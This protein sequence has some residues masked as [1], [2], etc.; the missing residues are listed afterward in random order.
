MPRTVLRQFTG[1]LSN[2]IDPQNLRE[3]QGEEAFDINLKGHA[4]EPGESTVPINAAGHYYYRGEWIE[5]SK[6][7]SFEESGIGVVKTFDSKRPVFEEI[8]KDDEN[9]SRNLGPPLPP[10]AVITGTIVSEGTRGERPGEGSHLLKLPETTLGGVDTTQSLE[11]HQADVTTAI[12][13]MHYYDGQPYWI[14][15][16]GSNNENWVIRT[17]KW[18]L[19][20][21]VVTWLT[22]YLD[23]TT[24]THNSGGS[25]FKDGYFVCWDD[26]YIDSVALSYTA[27]TADVQNTILDADGGDAGTAFSSSFLSGATGNSITGVDIDGNGII[28]FSQRMTTPNTTP[29][30][31]LYQNDRSDHERWLR[32]P[33]DS[34]NRGCF[35]VFLRDGMAHADSESTNVV[36]DYKTEA[37][38]PP[39]KVF[40]TEK[41]GD[42]NIFPGWETPTGK[43]K[44]IGREYD[45]HGVTPVSAKDRLQK[46]LDGRDD[47]DFGIKYAVIFAKNDTWVSVRYQDPTGKPPEMLV[48]PNALQRGGKTGEQAAKDVTCTRTLQS[49]K[50]KSTWSVTQ[51]RLPTVYF[52]GR[53]IGGGDHLF[54]MGYGQIWYKDT[55]NIELTFPTLSIHH[56]KVKWIYTAPKD[57]GFSSYA[58][59]NVFKSEDLGTDY[60]RR[61]GKSWRD[62]QFLW[63]FQSTQTGNNGTSPD[64]NT[65]SW[66]RLV[67]DGSGMGLRPGWQ[68][69]DRTGD[70]SYKNGTV[71][72]PTVAGKMH[73]LCSFSRP[74]GT[75]VQQEDFSV[76]ELWTYAK[77]SGED[78][79]ISFAEATNKNF[80]VGD[81]IKIGWNGTNKSMHL[82]LVGTVRKEIDDHW[83][84][85]KMEQTFITAKIIGI[86][87]GKLELSDPEYDHNKNKKYIDEECYPLIT[88]FIKYDSSRKVTVDEA[89]GGP[90]CS[91]IKS[92]FSSHVLVG[93]STGRLFLDTPQIGLTE[94][95]V[96]VRGAGAEGINAAGFNQLD[97][98]H[99]IDWTGNEVRAVEHVVDSYRPRIFYTKGGTLYS[100]NG[101]NNSDPRSVNLSINGKYYVDGK[102]LTHI[103][104]KDIT[105][106]SPNLQEEFVKARPKLPSGLG[107]KGEIQDARTF[108]NSSNAVFV[109][110]KIGG[111][112]KV[113]R[114]SNIPKVG[115]ETSLLNYD[116]N[117]PI[118]FD[119]TKIWGIGSSS[120]NGWDLQNATPFYESDVIGSYVYFASTYYDAALS[121]AATALNPTKSAWG[122]V[123]DT[124]LGDT[125]DTGTPRYLSVHWETDSGLLNSTGTPTIGLNHES[126][127]MV[128]EQTFK[129]YPIDYPSA[130]YSGTPN[131]TTPIVISDIPG[132]TYIPISS[133]EISF[134]S[135][136]KRDV[137]F[138]KK[139]ETLLPSAGDTGGEN[140]ITFLNYTD[141][142]QAFYVLSDS[143]F[144][145]TDQVGREPEVAFRLGQANV[146]NS[147][148][149][150]SKV[151]ISSFLLGAPNMFNAYGPNIDIYYRASF[152][153]KWG[154][155]G[156][157]SPLPSKGIAPLNS[158]DDCVQVNFAAPFFKLTD[159]DIEKIRLYRY[160]G[161]SSEFLYLRDID[162]PVL[163]VDSDGNSYFPTISGF[164]GNVA[165]KDSNS[166]FY[167]L[168]TN[169][170]ISILGGFVNSNFD[171]TTTVTTASAQ[172]MNGSW[173]INQLSE[174]ES[175]SVVYQNELDTELT[176]SATTIVTDS[177]NAIGGWPSSG[178]VKIDDEYISYTGITHPNI[179]GCTRG[180]YNSNAVIHKIKQLNA[181]P[182]Q[183]T[184]VEW[185]LEMEHRNQDTTELKIEIE[186]PLTGSVITVAD[187]SVFNNSGQILIG[188]DIYNYTAKTAAGTG[189]ATADTFTT[190]T[191][192]SGPNSDHKTN[193]LVR[194]YN[195]VYNTTDI[196]STT[197]VIDGFGYRDKAR[198]PVASLH[199]M[200]VDNWPPLGIEYN[201]GTKRFFETESEDDYFRYIKAVGSM[202]FGA[203]DASLRFSK[204]GT[205]EYWPLEAVVTLDSEIR[206]IEEH[207]GE[208]IVFTTN[209]VYR[210]RGTDPKAMIAFRVPDAKGLPAGYEHTV[211]D[212]NGGLIWLTASDGIAMYQSGRVTYLTRDKH[213]IGEL[214]K[215]YSCV[216]DGVY[217]L[218]QEPG[219]G[220]GFRLELV[221]G[222]MRLAQTSIEAYYAYFAKALGI[223]V[224]VTKDN[225][226]NPNVDTEFVVEEIGGIKA[227]NIS[228]KSKKIDAGEPAIPKALGS[229]AIVYQALGSE[230][231]ETIVD[232]IRGQALAAQ[233]LGLDPADL[234]AGD[235]A[236]V[237]SETSSDLYSIFTKYNEPHQEFTVDIGGG[238]LTSLERRTIIMP[239][240][241]DATTVIAGDRIWN[242]LLADNT[243]VESSS[244]P[245]ELIDENFV[246]TAAGTG[247]G[248]HNDASFVSGDIV[249]ESFGVNGFALSVMCESRS[250]SLGWGGGSY[251][252]EGGLKIGTEVVFLEP[253]SGSR[254]PASIIAGT[255]YYIQGVGGQPVDDS[256]QLSRTLGGGEIRW[257]G[258]ELTNVIVT[259]CTVST[260]SAICTCDT[261]NLEVG[262]ISTS[263]AYPA[264][265]KIIEITSSTSMILDTNGTVNN[266][267]Q[268]ISFGD[269]GEGT[270]KA[271][272]C[273]I[274][275]TDGGGTGFLATYEVNSSTGAIETVSIKDAGQG[276]TSVP[277][278]FV[279]SDPYNDTYGTT[280]A[281]GAI[282]RF[283]INAEIVL[284]KEPLRTGTGT[285]Y[286]GNLPRVEVYLNED[287]DPSRIYTLPPGDTD[288][289]QS[290]DLYLN[291]LKRFRTIS[292]SI[293]G[294]VRVQALSLRHYPLQ[295]YQSA[296]LHHSAD[297][298]YKGDVDFRVILDG[299]LIYRKELTNAGDD[300]KEERIYLPSSSFGQRV[301]YMNESRTGMIESV[302]FNGSVAA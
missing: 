140:R 301:H 150:A 215:P 222:E 5:D 21:G 56:N 132:N 231:A 36:G 235:I 158:A 127:K 152:I 14:V 70:G 54:F 68:I 267:N 269:A 167:L 20:G 192:D 179:T 191:H 19:S 186:G 64:S 28:S 229:V 131:G 295:S 93:H 78:N 67:G 120:T 281:S 130:F 232:G 113:V 135:E 244:T 126:D 143:A 138:F 74:N 195:E 178:V 65:G 199:S 216:V 225:I 48:I 202:Y 282:I 190:V 7:V 27:M 193:S 6:A 94:D 162:M 172:T 87:S 46:D 196:A 290:M 100:Q 63:D 33:S 61:H 161:D 115:A 72:S 31:T 197:I 173:R 13:D 38:S 99:R 298:F 174:N 188:S 97:Y 59:Y 249:V 146:A 206:C 45:G 214:K 201:V 41:G 164:G 189:S 300:F 9:V 230:R 79:S 35:V 136:L 255:T 37:L 84:A 49:D 112:W 275:A 18:T 11:L 286:W 302:K 248:T 88:G 252:H 109:C 236:A 25:F 4:L 259:G 108:V 260:S 133:I 148:F 183:I 96:E 276:Y 268:T 30:K 185:I 208:G 274:K 277:S 69:K 233:L 262:W 147:A 263:S 106:Y 241:F 289:T 299:N 154:H 107:L 210:C 149:D 256:W 17:R 123:T 139:S 175:P 180:I 254:L 101:S 224:V 187:T 142:G 8:I 171:F 218:F 166:P 23:S 176:A 245:I 116:F 52:L 104:N 279:I 47:V 227:T 177:S 3:D 128:G 181:A 111:Y 250:G 156:A 204:Y 44:T 242:E 98:T 285:I 51:H 10:A 117:K 40:T 226:L 293:E 264:G 39:P 288:E 247:Y 239:I 160:G 261:S 15:K 110:V 251:P 240:D 119:G 205:P 265:T 198:T 283:Q 228:W 273:F 182:T 77:I 157:P 200:Q 266:S 253:A 246:V 151:G 211:S 75:V 280:A 105:I 73:R 83:S 91:V 207:A 26:T 234:D 221:S 212:Y 62:R 137:V 272:A 155:E 209:S 85:I 170:D 217:W 43:M 124:R 129:W 81:W 82:N 29:D 165:R 219:S 53:K 287:D 92:G 213:D 71:T 16:S 163:P 60:A 42:T 237:E 168:K 34:S 90:V 125:S 66:S 258:G 24:L 153:N 184:V 294:N 134:K 32:M 297:V 291:D 95:I 243:T 270:N 159:T 118:G 55:V 76:S 238:N 257:D 144:S 223:G 80:R 122:V 57:G 169:Y 145:L 278:V 296:T 58:Y 220:S 50:V 1:G 194:S 292:V 271:S 103:D 141:A 114:T 284:D 121:N 102:Y 12:D 2:E 22:T 203:L 89:T 86:K